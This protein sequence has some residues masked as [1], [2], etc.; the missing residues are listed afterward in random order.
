M[1][2][3]LNTLA[4]ATGASRAFG[5]SSNGTVIVGDADFPAGAFT[6]KGA[7]R[8]AG[9]SYTDL[10]PGLNPSLAT[11][12]SADGTVVVGQTGT[13]SASSAFRWTAPPPPAQPVM[14]PIGPLPG[15]TT[16]AA[17]GVSD[18]GKIVVGISA[19][20]FLQYQ[21][22]VLGWSQGTAFRWAE[23]GSNAGIKDLRQL[24]VANGVDMTGITLV[25]VTGMSPDGQWIQGK[26]QTSAGDTT[27]VAQICD[28]AIGG[29]CSTTGAAPFTLGA[30]PNQ[31]T[32]SAGNSGITTITVTP[33]AGF[34]QPVSFSCGNLPVGAACSFSP[35]TVTPPS[36]TSTTL[37]ITTNGGPVALLSPG[38]STTMFASLLTP[39][40][41]I[42]VGFLVRRWR[43]DGLW[44]IAAGCLVTLAVVGLLSCSSGDSPPPAVTSG[45]GAATGTPAGTSTVSVTA[46]SGAGST[47]IPVTLTVTRP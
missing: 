32:V 30:A 26:A 13:T 35:A 5:V 16:A 29:P 44:C 2:V 42:P 9:G 28:E 43:P 21:G 19:P 40:V 23:S 12:V 8:W 6:R 37:T 31:L 7:F 20:G 36:T 47:G 18:N 10:I 46:T 17:T 11:A 3:D 41:F 39:I 45:G 14:Q 25:S 27:F 38:P 22:P 34:S 1:L 33:N 15:H 24:L 4:G